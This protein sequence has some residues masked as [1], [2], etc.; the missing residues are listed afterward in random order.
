MPMTPNIV[1]IK[2]TSNWK[3]VISEIEVSKELL[4]VT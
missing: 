2:N 4:I 1:F 3:Y